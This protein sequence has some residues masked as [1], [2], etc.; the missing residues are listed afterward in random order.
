MYATFIVSE[1]DFPV[2]HWDEVRGCED[3]VHSVPDGLVLD[4]G[5]EPVMQGLFLSRTES[6]E[7]RGY[8][9]LVV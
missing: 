2:I 6:A 3:E 8:K 1:V 7:G 5:G 4:T 9:V